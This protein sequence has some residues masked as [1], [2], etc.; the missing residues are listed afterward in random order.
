MSTATQTDPEPP[1]SLSVPPTEI[2]NTGNTN[3]D[4]PDRDI[5]PPTESKI[6]VLEASTPPNMYKLSI[7]PEEG[8]R[9]P[10]IQVSINGAEVR[11]LLDSGADCT[12]IS[13][14]AAEQIGLQDVSTIRKSFQLRTADE[15]VHEQ[16]TLYLL[17]YEY[18]G[19][20]VIIPTVVLPQLGVP[21]VLGMDF[22]H[23]FGI[24]PTINSINLIEV[25]ETE[26]FCPVRHEHVLTEEQKKALDAIV[27]QLPFSRP[28]MI[29]KTDLLKHSIDTG[30]AAPVRRKPRILSPY[31]EELVK[32]EIGRMIGLDVIEPADSAWSN[33]MVPVQKANGK[34]RY[35]IDAR[36]LNAVTKPDAYPLQNLNRIL[37]RLTKT[38]YLSSIDLSDA[39]WQVELVEEDRPKTAFSV[40]GLGFFQF[41]RMPF[42]LI[43]SAATLCK[44][45]DRV[46]GEDLEPRVFRYLDDF[47]I[48]TQTFEEH[49][50]MIQEV[51]ARLKRAGLTMSREKSKFCMRQLTYVGYL[52]DENGCRPDPQK[53]SAVLNFPVPT[54]IKETRRF[55]GMASWYRRFI[56]GFATLSAAI[57]ELTKTKPAQKFRWTPEAQVAFEKLKSHLTVAPVL[58]MPQYEGEWILETDASDVGMGGCLKQVQD[59]EERV[60]IYF[61]K[62]LSKAARKYTVTE[63]ECLAV[64]TFIERSRPY[65]E[66]VPSFTVVTDHA[67]LKWLQNLQDPTGRLARWALRLQAINYKIIHRPGAK[68]VVADAL[69]RAVTMIEVVEV[70]QQ[71]DTEYM[72]LLNEVR[73]NPASHP[74][75]M[76]HQGRLYRRNHAG[77]HDFNG[78]WKLV[79]PESQRPEVLHE[80][81]D[82]INAAHG[83]TFKTL[84]RVRRAYFWPG[85]RK[86]VIKHVKD[87]RICKT[88]K[89]P[90]ANQKA[91]MGQERIPRRKFQMLCIDF[92]GPLPESGRGNKWILVAIDNFT[93]YVV[94]EPIHQ[95]T[96][97]E[98]IRTLEEKVIAKFGCPE[99]II[100][101][102]G[103]QLRSKAMQDFATRY[104]ITLWYTAA[105]H[106][107]ANPTEAA[108][109]T[110][111][112]GI[113]AYMEYR[114]PQ[115]TWDERLPFVIAAMNSS[116][117][118]ST[119][120][121]PN[122]A[123]FGEDI[124]T[125]GSDHRMKFLDDDDEAMPT[126]RRFENI[127][128]HVMDHL[129]QSYEEAAARYNA[130]AKPREYE[131]GDVVYKRNFKLSNASHHYMAKLDHQFEA[132]RIHERLGSNCYTFED[133]HGK[134]L[135]GT[136]SIQDIRP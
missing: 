35:C 115:Q 27:A 18:V 86:Q 66:G 113:R 15:T 17:S 5:K 71:A 84:D 22:W 132:V 119:Q 21:V 42:G 74:M 39:Y 43:N 49:L 63:R 50:E 109:H 110:I 61:S 31:M 55:Y 118:S 103:P 45:V 136:F 29:G 106:P 37:G 67:S 112:K 79:V 13:A 89:P 95:S 87:C 28:G 77:D 38:K 12:V 122:M 97:A 52:I 101:D 41:K 76:E 96:A 33:M 51:G 81:H 126:S 93:K 56:S 16:N 1:V 62:K 47:I 64:I 102:N 131:P 117:H 121:T 36:P 111:V 83:G 78:T 8:E 60:I 116:K 104:K 48:A 6:Q 14:R 114:A 127:R 54:N 44:L 7:L 72:G 129:Q 59:G 73:R 26:E 130:R 53:I 135:P 10:F 30:D 32:E 25:E 11:A 123:V 107:Q 20:S 40:P 68:M 99:V 80:C 125:L 9:R 120:V 34:L 105:Y 82:S 46:V 134:I 69:S 88:T 128:A 3:V 100:L 19:R 85:L 23:A 65:L 90:N 75:Y 4:S 70:A 98:T 108:N 57:T 133:L 124:A 2:E 24:T 92:I 94:A 91:Y 58:A